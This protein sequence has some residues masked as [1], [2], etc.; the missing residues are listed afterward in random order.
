MDPTLVEGS[1]DQRLEAYRAIRDGILKRIKDR[2][3]E[4]QA[5]DT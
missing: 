2:F 1:R 3:A 5:S 4:K